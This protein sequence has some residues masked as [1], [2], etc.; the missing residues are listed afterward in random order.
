VQQFYL[1][2]K[3]GEAAQAIPDEL[4][5]DVALCGP[6]A[7]IKERLELWRNSPVT[8]LNLAQADLQAVRLM[9]ELVL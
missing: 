2:G 9:A 5:D 1:Q 7:R 3:K 8:T 4:V 6:P